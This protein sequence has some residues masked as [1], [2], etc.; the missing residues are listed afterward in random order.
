VTGQLSLSSYLLFCKVVSTICLVGLLG[1][2]DEKAVG[3][4][5]GNGHLLS[6]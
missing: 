2:P 6:R 4:G 3:L 5:F 1:A